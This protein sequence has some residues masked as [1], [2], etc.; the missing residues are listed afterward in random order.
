MGRG[1]SI[2]KAGW[3]AE[4][5]RLRRFQPRD[6]DDPELGDWIAALDCA[7]AAA[8]GPRVL[9]AHSLACLL[10]AH[11]L[12]ASP[13]PV[14]GV[15][16][17]STPDPEG[18]KFP[19]QA[20]SFANPPTQKF[21]CPAL[22]LASS[23]DP[24][25]T[26]DYARAMAAHWGSGLIEMGALGHINAHSGLGAWPEGRALLAAFVAGVQKRCV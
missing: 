22:M 12:L 10:V 4:D 26:L 19:P 21:R 1:P 2:G 17:V 13:L 15:V 18:A 7:V 23:N 16:L 8:K 20:K 6:W 24:Y 9:V 25:G 14:A 11:W 3:E 5:G